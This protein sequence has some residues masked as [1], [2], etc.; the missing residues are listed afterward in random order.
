MHSR[1]G[2][3]PFSIQTP[4][5]Q[6]VFILC[7]WNSMCQ[8]ARSPLRTVTTERRRPGQKEWETRKKNSKAEFLRQS[9]HKHA[10]EYGDNGSQPINSQLIF[11][12]MKSK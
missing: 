6:K 9:T 2:W 1:I 3:K 12:L 11:V 8:R 10:H 7:E 4:R 5:A